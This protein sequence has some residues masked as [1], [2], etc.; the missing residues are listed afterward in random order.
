MM[1]TIGIITIMMVVTTI[2]YAM[3]SIKRKKMSQEISR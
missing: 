3:T 2:F 1:P